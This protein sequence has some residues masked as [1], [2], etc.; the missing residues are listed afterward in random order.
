[1]NNISQWQPFFGDANGIRT[2]LKIGLGMPSESYSQLRASGEVY[3][4]NLAANT[5]VAFAVV[6]APAS[7]EGHVYYSSVDH[8]LHVRG[9]AGWETISSA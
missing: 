4:G 2:D 9:A 1:M 6:T 7:T 3:G 5:Y 8:K